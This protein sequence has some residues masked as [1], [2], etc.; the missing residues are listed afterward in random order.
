MND[1]NKSPE[2]YISTY[3]INL[4]D[5][6]ERRDHITSEFNNK[7]EFDMKIIDAC[8]HEIG[9]VGLWNS[10]IEIVKLA[11]EDDEDVIIICEDDHY[12]TENYSSQYLFDNIFLAHEQCADV[13]SGGIGG[14]GYAVPIAENR[15]W[16]DFLWCTQFIVVY[17]K[18]FQKILDY[19]FKDNDTADGVISVLSNNLVTLYPFISRQKSFGYSDITQSIKDSPNLIIDLFNQ[20]DTKLSAVHRVSTFYNYSNHFE[21]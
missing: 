8:I 5:R 19:N 13:L 9:A 11:V 12:F 6:K 3:V 10:I 4:R 17:K 1:K 2:F 14:F 7:P 16:I 15:Y 20:A 18:M 21:K